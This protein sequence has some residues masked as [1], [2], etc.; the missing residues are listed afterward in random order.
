MRR[1]PQELIGKVNAKEVGAHR[2]NRFESLGR[3]QQQRSYR[4]VSLEVG[5]VQK[6]A[7]SRPICLEE[8]LLQGPQC[9]G[10]ADFDVA[11]FLILSK[12][13][14]GQANQLNKRRK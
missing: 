12:P 14:H 1:D 2:Q 13:N 6:T 4:D 5:Q 8:R 10:V 11:A 7:T 3:L 9:I